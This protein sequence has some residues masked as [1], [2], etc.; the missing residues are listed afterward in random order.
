[1]NSFDFITECK[2]DNYY[3]DSILKKK[4]KGL[5]NID[6]KNLTQNNDSNLDKKDETCKPI[7]SMSSNSNSILN[8]ISINSDNSNKDI[9]KS[10]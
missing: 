2:N 7:K 4:T 9:N 1:M 3:C 10:K 5:F 6:I 8:S